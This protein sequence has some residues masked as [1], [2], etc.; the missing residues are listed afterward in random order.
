MSVQ[1]YNLQFDSLARYAPTIVD[2]IEDRV[3]RF[4]MGLESHLLNDCM[5]VSLQPCMDISRIQAY[6][7][8]VEECKQKQRADCEHDRGQRPSQNS[9]ASSSQYRG[10]SSQMRS[11]LPLCAQCDKQHAGQCRMWL[12]VCYTYG[13]LGHIMRYC[14]TRGDASIVQPAGSVVG[15]SS[16][17][18]PPGQGSQVPINRGRGRGRASSSSGPQ[19]RIYALVGRQDHESSPDVVTGLPPERETEFAIDIL[20]D[21]HPISIPPYRMALKDI[22]TSA[23]TLTLPEGADGY[24]IYCDASGI[25]LGGVLMQHGKVVAYASRKLRKHKK[26]YP[27]HDLELA[28]VIHALKMWRRWLDLLKDYD[29]DILYHPGKANVVTDALN[30]RSMGSLSYLQPG[31]SGI[32]CDIHKLASLGVRL[33]DSCDTGI[34]IQDTTTSSL[35]TEVKE[36]QY[37]DHVLAHYRDTTPQKDKTPFKIT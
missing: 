13:Y 26:N 29:V 11:P 21:I 10:E 22:L 4:V 9:K 7:Q 20:P 32:A 25:G 1:E 28:A 14:P 35:V 15:S 16:S 8:G 3:H 24:A 18:R 2:K 27:T 37:E 6:S 12:G 17:V 5:S 30:R 23:P 33:L 36:R 19:N 34:T 31:K